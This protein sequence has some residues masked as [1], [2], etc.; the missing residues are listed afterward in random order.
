MKNIKDAKLRDAKDSDNFTRDYF[1]QLE[2]LSGITLASRSDKWDEALKEL[3]LKQ[4]LAMR[5]SI[6]IV[7]SF[8]FSSRAKK[9]LLVLTCPLSCSCDCWVNGVRFARMSA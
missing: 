8:S 2:G 1:A 4:R 3:S 5:T 9:I 7:R 6:F